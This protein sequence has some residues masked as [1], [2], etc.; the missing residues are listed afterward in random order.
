M[1]RQSH[2]VINKRIQHRYS[3]VPSSSLPFCLFVCFVPSQCHLLNSIKS[4]LGLP[5]WSGTKSS[6]VWNC[7]SQMNPFISPLWSPLLAQSA[8]PRCRWSYWEEFRREVG[9]IASTSPPRYLPASRA[10]GR[11]LAFLFQVTDLPD[12]GVN[13]V[14]WRRSQPSIT[15]DVWS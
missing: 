13:N 4:A 2:T 11:N 7:R 8:Q 6:V 14:H 9:T 3:K 5:S 12:T 10:A 1:T 15:S